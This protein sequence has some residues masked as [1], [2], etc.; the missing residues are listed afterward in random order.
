[1]DLLLTAD[2]HLSATHPE[3][4][5]ALEEIVRFANTENVSY[6]LIAGD[7][8][9]ADLEVETI[10]PRIRNLFSGNS[11]QVFVIPG[12]HDERAFREED[13]FGDDIEVLATRPL[14]TL[15]LGGVNL[16]A[17][18]F[19]KRGFDDLVDAVN[20]AR[21]EEKLNVLLI[22]GTLS[23]TEGKG[24]GDEARYLPFTPEQL[25]ASGM[26]YV[27]AGHIHSSPI[28]Q[29]FGTDDCVFVYPGSPVSIT[30]NETGRRGAWLFNTDTES[31]RNIPLD[32]HYYVH[33]SIDL[34]PGEAPSKLDALS[35]RLAKTD[36]ANAT[37]LV[38]PTG[39]IEIPEAEFFESLE[40][41]LADSTAT[42]Y[43]IDRSGVQS[44]KTI[45][46]SG[47]YQEFNDKLTQKAD[48]DARA[49]RRITLRA[50]SQEARE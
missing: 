36:L 5:A 1:M 25:V 23:T 40:T 33:E 9:D 35:E 12:N 21:I 26:D 14:Q 41:I 43:H 30:R 24:S 28:R 32:S 15:E 46:E 7:M 6:V 3:R 50:L 17:V 16:V 38:E 20:D 42:D 13:Y 27:F 22:H 31:F 34:I 19:V 8:F 37:I 39:F 18:P 2:I 45:L 44:A 47:L 49:V 11:F 29:S 4:L 10:K 48:V